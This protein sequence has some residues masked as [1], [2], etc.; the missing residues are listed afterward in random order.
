MITEKEY[1]KKIYRIRQEYKTRL[2]K[3]RLGMNEYVEHMPNDLYTEIMNNFSIEK[4]SAYP[5]VNQAYE[6][7][8]KYLKQSRDRILLTSGADMAIK[9][10]FETFCNEG[11][12]I[13]TCS[14]TFAMYKIH[15]ELLNCK[16]IETMS[17]EKGDFTEEQL[18][19]LL[20]HNVKL[21]VIANPS[22]V[23]GF[24]FKKSTI[25]KLLDEANQ[26]NTVVLLDETYAS[27][28]NID[29]SEFIEKYKNLVIV[30]SFSKNIGMAGLRI[31]YILSSEYLT[32]MMEKFKPMMEINSLAVEAVKAI[33]NNPKYIN[34]A[35]K[36]IQS[37]RKELTDRI[38]NM[39]YEV[40]EKKGNFI[41]VDFK[42]D[43]EK[44]EKKLKENNVEYKIFNEP[45]H[46]Y[47]RFTIGTKKIMKKLLSLI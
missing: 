37:N 28:D 39:G 12:I 18:L 21:L 35:C 42:G 8:S 38:R 46:N 6:S 26:K 33:C 3:I 5:E 9:V 7:L 2:N 34:D 44:I 4:A 31:G 25:D 24:C 41:L 16:I 32:N 15:A 14:P 19:G 23:T 40:I 22:G 36:E 29:M 20:E 43:R 30:R 45:L 47:I 11:D 13:A 27:F 1:A 17:D 10:V